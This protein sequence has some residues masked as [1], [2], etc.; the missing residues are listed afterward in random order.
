MQVNWLQDLYPEVALR[1]GVN[2]LKPIA[3]ALTAARNAGRTVVITSDHG[4]IIEYRTS[5]KVDRTNTYGQRAHGDFAHVD[6]DREVIV[7][8]PRVLTA[9]HRA[10]LAVDENIRYGACNAG[11]HGGGSPAEAVVPVVVLATGPPVIAWTDC[12]L[13]SMALMSFW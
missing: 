10:V 4:H 6:P 9:G 8:G 2:A 5:A 11:Y 7:E 12:R 3:P 13:D 1:L